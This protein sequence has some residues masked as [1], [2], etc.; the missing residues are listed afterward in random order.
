MA[1]NPNTLTAGIKQ[2]WDD[3]YQ[4]VHYKQPTYRAF[5]DFGLAAKLKVGNTVTRVYT[6]DLVV[7]DMGADGSYQRQAL[8]DTGES[9]VINKEK[10][11]SFYIKEL[12][13]LQNHLP[14][15]LKY[16]RKAMNK[17]FLKVDGDVIGATADGAKNV[18]DNAELGGS[19]GDAIS[20]AD[21]NIDD[22]INAA[23]RALELENV[24]LDPAARF[25]GDV[26]KDAFQAI[27]M[28]IVSPHFLAQLRKRVGGKDSD[29]GDKVS[30]NGHIGNYL[31]FELFLSN[32]LQWTAELVM[33]TNPTDGETIT[34]NGVAWTF[35]DT[36]A[37]AAQIKIGANAA[38]TRLNVVAAINDAGTEGTNYN[39]VSAANRI[40]L[41]NITATDDASNTK[42][43]F[44]GTG[45]GYVQVAETLSAAADVWTAAKQIQHNLFLV[46]GAC[47]VVI[48]KTPEMFAERRDGYVGFDVVTW[49]AYG[50]KVFDDQ[51]PM[52]VN[53]KIQSS[54]W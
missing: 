24:I 1:A 43:T 48:Q 47:S 25:T 26:K 36:L 51:K 12:D 44:K 54:S 8:T 53:A 2:T 15:R 34:I 22:V 7:N 52:V 17:L 38:A 31:G 16:A 4:I 29:L 9:L 5:A 46:R 18:V 42:I 3:V 32:A 13:E 40:K 19:S 41:A 11:A 27:P 14:T 35:K 39:D 30:V 6:S 20:L 50:F 33:A 37:A 49:T 45:V 23:R 21:T 10:E 28:A